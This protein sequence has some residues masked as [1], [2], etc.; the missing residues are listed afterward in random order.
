MK[1]SS[2]SKRSL[3]AKANHSLKILFRIDHH[4]GAWVHWQFQSCLKRKMNGYIVILTVQ[5]IPA[6]PFHNFCPLSFLRTEWCTWGSGA[7]LGRQCRAVQAG[8]PKSE[9]EKHGGRVVNGGI[10]SWA[11]ELD[12]CRLCIDLVTRKPAN[13]RGMPLTGRLNTKQSCRSWNGFVTTCCLRM[14]CRPTRFEGTV[15]NP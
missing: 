11:R 10:S 4:T 7:D 8:N 1:K 6:D 15:R 14:W 5:R 9:R 2:R 13:S 3:K 12:F